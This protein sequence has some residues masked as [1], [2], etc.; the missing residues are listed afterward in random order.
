MEGLHWSEVVTIA[1]EE[2]VKVEAGR[3]MLQRST[4]SVAPLVFFFF[5]LLLATGGVVATSRWS[6]VVHSNGI[7]YIGLMPVLSRIES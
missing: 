3:N 6:L 7:G 5:W 4:S 1:V 2:K